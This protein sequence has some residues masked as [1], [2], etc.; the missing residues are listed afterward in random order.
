MINYFPILAS[1][2]KLVKGERGLPGLPVCRFLYI[3][4]LLISVFQNK[5]E[6]TFERMY[7]IYPNFMCKNRNIKMLI[8]TLCPCQY[9]GQT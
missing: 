6:K 1:Q 5:C 2:I 7:K 4:N 8:D 9:L 3:F